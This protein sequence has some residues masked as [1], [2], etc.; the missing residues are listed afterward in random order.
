MLNTS[1][2]ELI[3]TI[4]HKWY[5]IVLQPLF[6]LFEV[7]ISLSKIMRCIMAYLAK[8]RKMSDDWLGNISISSPLIF[9]F[10]LFLW[11]VKRKHIKEV[12]NVALSWKFYNI[13]KHL[14]RVIGKS[15]LCTECEQAGNGFGF[16][17]AVEWP[18]CRE[19]NKSVSTRLTES[20]RP[21]TPITL[22]VSITGIM[23]ARR[24]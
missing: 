4:C 17:S 8:L 20:K 19:R 18:V 13:I 3:L 14:M 12:K 11:I 24:C 1:K 5:R 10:S 9:L 7:R 21:R 15:A 22:I 16:P 6:N 23:I 2:P